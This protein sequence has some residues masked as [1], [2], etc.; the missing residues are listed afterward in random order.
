MASGSETE[1]ATKS[2]VHENAAYEPSESAAA[3]TS[4]R[5]ARQLVRSRERGCACPL[6]LTFRGSGPR[7]R[8]QPGCPAVKSKRRRRG[9]RPRV[10]GPHVSERPTT[11]RCGAAT[12]DGRPCRQKV[13]PEA[14]CKYHG[15][16][17]TA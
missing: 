1:S 16:G 15:Q 2:R 7:W 8:H 13:G 12:R 5:M 6:D 11:S 10:E 3:A 17:G 4:R 14:P 9:V